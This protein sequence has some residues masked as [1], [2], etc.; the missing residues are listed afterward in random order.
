MP[1]V[2]R[3]RHPASGALLLQSSASL[4][5]VLLQPLPQVVGLDQHTLRIS[6]LL[7]PLV[8]K[9]AKVGPVPR[10]ALGEP[11]DQFEVDL[12]AVLL[13]HHAVRLP[14]LVPEAELF[15]QLQIGPDLFK[16]LVEVV[17][18]FVQPQLCL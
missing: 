13:Y 2:V 10:F 18:D 1:S 16:A 15:Q 3:A 8:A 4:R 11:P 9:P 5:P 6:K 12:G 7:L 14:R 17:E